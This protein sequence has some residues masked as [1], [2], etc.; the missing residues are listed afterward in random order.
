MRKED[1]LVIFLIIFQNVTVDRA[2]V[3]L[4]TELKLENIQWFIYQWMIQLL[5]EIVPNVLATDVR[6]RK[7]TGL[8]RRE[9]FTYENCDTCIDYIWIFKKR[10]SSIFYTKTNAKLYFN[11]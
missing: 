11:E 1:L 6:S 10:E 2:I 5:I 9:N 4:L 8:N 3:Y 7:V